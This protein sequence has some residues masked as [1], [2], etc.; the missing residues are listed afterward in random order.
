MDYREQFAVKPG[1]KIRLDRID[2]G[3]KGDHENAEKAA[4]ARG[5][6]RVPFTRIFNRCS[7]PK[8]GIPC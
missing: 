1:E 2:P 3:F 6:V 5:A 7:M 4:D 8:S